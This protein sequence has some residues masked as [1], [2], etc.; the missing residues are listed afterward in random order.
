[1]NRALSGRPPQ[2]VPPLRI[3]FS[4]PDGEVKGRLKVDRRG[5]VRLSRGRGLFADLSIT[6]DAAALEDLLT[7]GDFSSA[8]SFIDEGRIALQGKV[9]AFIP[10]LVHL[11]SVLGGRPNGQEQEGNHVGR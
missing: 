7:G 4:S 5:R 11:D 2:P 3:R 10:T 9:S 8:E 1:M 6:G